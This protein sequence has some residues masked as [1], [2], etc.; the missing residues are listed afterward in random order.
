MC[1]KWVIQNEYQA[2]GSGWPGR[3]RPHNGVGPGAGVLLPTSYKLLDTVL[4]NLYI[5][6]EIEDDA[7]EKRVRKKR[8][9]KR[10]VGTPV[11]LRAKPAPP[12]G[13]LVRGQRKSTSSFFSELREE[14]PAVTPTSAPVR[15]QILHA[16]AS[17]SPLTRKEPVEVVELH[18]R[19]KKR[20]QMPDQ[21]EN[22]K[23]KTS[24]LEKDGNI[25]EFN[26]EKAQLQVH[27]FGITGCGKRKNR[28]LEPECVVILCVQSPK[29]SYVNYKVLQ[30]QIKGGKKAAKEEEKRVAQDTDIFK[31]KKRKGQ[32][33]R[34]SK[35]KKSAPSI[36]SSSWIG[37]VVKLK[38]GTLI[39]SQVDIKKINSSQVAKWSG[40]QTRGGTGTCHHTETGSVQDSS[41][42]SL[43]SYS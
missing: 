38:N 2:I 8:K 22:S 12:P 42:F 5:F 4:H 14:C 29:K 18:S 32:E 7:E 17:P 3:A 35:K 31:K 41:L 39:L 43:I 11:A 24:S 13:P 34:K 30:E 9:N 36:L 33:D 40:L 37:H 20:K 23:T 28:V 21:D 16:T 15:T 19:N 1:S 25:Q 26:L 27:R 10:D 6:G